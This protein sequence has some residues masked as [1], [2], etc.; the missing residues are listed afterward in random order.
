[1]TFKDLFLPFYQGLIDRE[2]PFQ[3]SPDF[4][5][6]NTFAKFT[7]KLLSLTTSLKV[8]LSA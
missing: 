6:Y 4:V 2:N 3:N 8:Y 7:Y 1:M 5:L